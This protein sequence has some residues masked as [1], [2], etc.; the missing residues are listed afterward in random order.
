LPLALTEA[1]MVP[2]F[3]AAVRSAAAGVV[4]FV[5]APQADNKIVPNT[6]TIRTMLHR[7]LVRMCNLVMNFR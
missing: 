2:R 6:S 5:C 7:L 3:A 4:E 1:R